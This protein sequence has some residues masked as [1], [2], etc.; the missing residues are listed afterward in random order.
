MSTVLDRPV[1]EAPA[2]I[3][4]A[5]FVQGRLVEGNAVRH[6]SRDL[7]IDFTTPAIDLDALAWC[8]TATSISSRPSS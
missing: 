5:H 3:R 2:A 6:T 8:S 1:E 7:G 4:A